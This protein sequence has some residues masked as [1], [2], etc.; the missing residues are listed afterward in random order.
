MGDENEPFSIS[1]RECSLTDIYTIWH[2]H[3]DVYT[4][5]KN[6]HVYVCVYTHSQQINK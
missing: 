3:D 5:Y 6:Y 4:D 2:L 1:Q